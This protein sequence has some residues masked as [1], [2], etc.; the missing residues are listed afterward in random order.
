M[1]KFKPLF[2]FY[3][4]LAYVTLQFCWWGYHIIDLNRELS[5]LQETTA[6]SKIS[7]V[8]GEG[9]VFLAI[10]TLGAVFTHKSFRKE[11]LLAA[12][13]QN[14][15]LSVS[16][17][18]KTPVAAVKLILETLLKRELP[19]EKEKELLKNALADNERL[20]SLLE[21]VLLATSIENKATNKHFSEIQLTKVIATAMKTL[22][23]MGYKMENI[24]AKLDD[25]IHVL[26]DK[27][28]LESI[29]INLLENALKHTP[30]DTSV[31]ILLFKQNTCVVLQV[32]DA[33]IGIPQDEK[34]RIFE[35]FYRRGNENTR[36]TKGTGLGLY[37]VKSLVT[38][39][40][41]KIRVN[42]NKPKGSI[43]EIV[44]HKKI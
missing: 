41:G 44:F 4:L 10:L 2:L 37:I 17:E 43:F 25:S 42:D 39:H 27:T 11:K 23:R 12:Q 3:L 21:N 6:S 30:E 16:H 5:I 31:E 29:V 20:T 36:Q 38:L 28:A 7:M 1:I 18:L 35:K 40:K 8:L 32:K 24:A 26:G 22:E 34:E 14:F 13:Q 33:G 19:K 9:L 15:L